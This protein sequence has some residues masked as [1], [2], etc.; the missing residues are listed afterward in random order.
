MHQQPP[1]L[2]AAAPLCFPPSAATAAAAVVSAAAYCLP[3]SVTHCLKY[4]SLPLI[5]TQANDF[6]MGFGAVA[7]PSGCEVGSVRAV[8]TAT[9]YY[10]VLLTAGFRRGRGVCRALGF[11]GL[12]V[13]VSASV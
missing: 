10:Q 1:T 3:L 13:F 12:C 4:H 11:G 7:V 6:P 2:L 5:T 9:D 8:L